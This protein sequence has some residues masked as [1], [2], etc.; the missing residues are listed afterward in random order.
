M[1]PFRPRN[2]RSKQC[3][4]VALVAVAA[5]AGVAPGC[6][7][8][9]GLTDAVV[10]PDAV[11]PDGAASDGGAAESSAADGCP[12][13]ASCPSGALFCESFETLD[14]AL[15]SL[16]ARQ[17]GGVQVGLTP[18]GRTGCS[19]LS[20]AL[21]PAT[22]KGDS[23]WGFLHRPIPSLP[24]AFHARTWLRLAN[25][26]PSVM[27]VLQLASASDK[28]IFQ[29]N[30]GTLGAYAQ[31]AKNGATLGSGDAPLPFPVDRW[32]CFEVTVTPGANGNVAATIDGALA[33]SFHAAVS[34]PSEMHV[35]FDYV[36][37]EKSASVRYDDIVVAG[38]STAIG[39][40]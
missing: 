14:P 10:D 37:P 4:P 7:L 38:G 5:M 21:A 22:A 30:A 17:A 1:V 31:D 33:L 36:L 18:G 19:A 12:P 24:G 20:V 15:W 39:C 34:V 40:D 6:S 28:I 23:T 25:G 26:V 29:L 35:G 3:N 11:R 16:D 13:V 8:V 2:A 27:T 9:L 32:T